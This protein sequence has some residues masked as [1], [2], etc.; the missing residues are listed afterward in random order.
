VAAVE[1]VIEALSD[2]DVDARYR[3]RRYEM[4]DGNQTWTIGDRGPGWTRR[5]LPFLEVDDDL[6][7]RR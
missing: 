7:R 3:T 6:P 2:P 4:R 5:N 1:A